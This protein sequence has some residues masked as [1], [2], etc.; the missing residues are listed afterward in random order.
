MG[1]GRLAFDQ[2]D[3]AFIDELA[4]FVSIPSVSRDA[5]PG[6]MR[7]AAEWLTGQ[8][9][10]ATPRIEP[11]QGHPVVRADWLGAPGAPTI[12]VYGHYD[13]L[14]ANRRNE[15]ATVK[16]S[17]KGATLAAAGRRTAG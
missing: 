13:V 1:T 2:P 8:L 17:A 12:L 3:T 5:S 4:E 7:Q 14:S 16:F 6:T 11:T 15:I 10:F 9:E